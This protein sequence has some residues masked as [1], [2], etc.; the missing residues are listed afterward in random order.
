V[1]TLSGYATSLDGK[2]LAFAIL[3]NN[4]NL[5]EKR[6]RDALDRIVE[7]IINDK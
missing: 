6:M 4:F 2:P 3:S 5:S 1:K 7:A